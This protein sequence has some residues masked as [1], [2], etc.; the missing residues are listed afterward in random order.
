VERDPRHTP[1]DI[2]R[3]LDAWS[4]GDPEARDRLVA[5][6]Y[7]EMRRR[8]AAYLRRE[9]AAMTLCGRATWC[10]RRTCA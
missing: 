9:P 10:A 2:T 5:T 7:G 4:H 8:A 3:L 1:G 6:V